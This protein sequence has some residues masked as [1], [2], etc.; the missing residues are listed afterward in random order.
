[1]VTEGSSLNGANVTAAAPTGALRNSSMDSSSV[2]RTSASRIQSS[3]QNISETTAAND[4]TSTANYCYLFCAVLGFASGLYLFYSFSRS[5]RA[6][7]NWTW[8]DSLLCALSVS[9]FI[10]LLCSL[11]SL[12]HRPGCLRT[13]DLNCTLLSFLF[14]TAL[15]SGQYLLVLMGFFLTFDQDPPRSPLLQRARNRPAVCVALTAALSLLFSALLAGLLGS[16]QWLDDNT[17]CRLDPWQD[18][19]GYKATKLVLGFVLPNLLLL[20]LL[21]AGCVVW[22]KS[23]GG[24]LSRL[25]AFPVF[26]SVTLLTFVCRMFYSSMLMKRAELSP[27]RQPQ[28]QAL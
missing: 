7:R 9:E 20:A 2:T 5:Y 25:K 28:C 26:L 17:N 18:A 11:S 6:R 23:N 4:L 8:L 27:S 24:F 10:I 14:N 22:G 3:T 1:M 19:D 15:F 12:A 13:T 16:Q 21:G